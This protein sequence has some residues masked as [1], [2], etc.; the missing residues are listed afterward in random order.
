MEFYDLSVHRGETFQQSLVFRDKDREL[1]DLTGYSGYAQVRP[2]P[3]SD[4][5]TASLLVSITGADGLAVLALSK[6]I[7]ETIEPGVY[8]YD[9]AM[10]DT[11]GRMR[12]YLGGKFTVLPTVT[13]TGA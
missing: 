1:I 13:K 12:Y 11:S 3:E 8:Y 7:T 4:E 5:L 10:K 6:E 9:F 2:E